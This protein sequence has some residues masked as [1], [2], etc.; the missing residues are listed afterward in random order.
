M[1]IKIWVCPIC[2]KEREYNENVKIKICWCCQ[3]EMFVRK[4]KK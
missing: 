2:N 4:V 1:T 3:T